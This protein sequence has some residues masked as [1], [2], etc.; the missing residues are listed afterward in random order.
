M[1]KEEKIQKLSVETERL[2]RI[3]EEISVTD[4]SSFWVERIEVLKA[5][6][7]F[8]NDAFDISR[9]TEQRIEEVINHDRIIWPKTE[10][11]TNRFEQLRDL[12][13]LIHPGNKQ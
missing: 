10:F 13:F 4:H 7:V 8:L 5:I 1:K 6:G 9:D 11:G 2:L 3:L 12:D